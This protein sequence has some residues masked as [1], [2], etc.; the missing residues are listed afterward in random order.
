MIG[1]LVTLRSAILE[2]SLIHSDDQRCRHRLKGNSLLYEGRTPSI[3]V[4]AAK[5]TIGANLI[6]PL[7]FENRLKWA[8][9]CTIIVQGIAVPL[10]SM[11]IRAAAAEGS[12]C[13]WEKDFIVDTAGPLVSGERR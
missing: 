3:A 10:G 4:V 6:T 7:A 12:P 11:A 5:S 9:R 8:R 1:S 2:L 13:L